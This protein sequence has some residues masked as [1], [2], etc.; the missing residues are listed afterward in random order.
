MSLEGYNPQNQHKEVSII[1][2][3]LFPI[4]R[5]EIIKEASEY[6]SRLERCTIILVIPCDLVQCLQA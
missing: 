3:P 2:H 5:V 1:T 4:K 6:V